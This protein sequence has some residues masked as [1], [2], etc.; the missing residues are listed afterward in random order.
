MNQPIQQLAEEAYRA[1]IKQ[2]RLMS[3]SDRFL[4]GA[5]LYDLTLRMARDGIRARY[6][7]YTDE[8]VQR[9]LMNRLR[10]QRTLDRRV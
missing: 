4:A 7:N 9:E 5:R 1:K 2:A 6:P 3:S 8:Q 10:I